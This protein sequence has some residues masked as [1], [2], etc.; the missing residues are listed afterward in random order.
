MIW[1]IIIAAIVLLGIIPLGIRAEYDD[2]GAFLSL[3][4][5][6]FGLQIYPRRR[7]SKCKNKKSC[8]KATSVKSANRNPEN[9]KSDGTWSDFCSIVD[10]VLEVLSDF[11]SKLRVNDLQLN[12]ILGGSDPC[13]LSVNY[14]RIWAAIGSLMPQLERLF[15]IKN[16]NIEVQCDYLADTTRVRARIHITITVA[17]LLS[18]VLYHGIRGFRKYYKLIK[19]I[20]GGATT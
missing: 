3:S 17:R 14:G 20:K 13:D 12:V 4:I 5:G 15:V 16:R 6:P 18:L 1:L 2:S 7:S 9:K 19:Q 11:R 10:F 8:A